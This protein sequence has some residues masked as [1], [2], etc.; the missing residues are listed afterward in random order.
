MDDNLPAWMDTNP[1]SAQ[2]MFTYIAQRNVDNMITGTIIAI[3]AISAILIL[4]MMEPAISSRPRAG[5]S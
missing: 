1:T 3:A 2:V 5:A 4:I